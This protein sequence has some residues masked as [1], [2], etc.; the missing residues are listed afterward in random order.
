M[1][2]DEFRISSYEERSALLVAIYVARMERSDDEPYQKIWSELITR[3]SQ[4]ECQ[5]GGCSYCTGEDESY[6]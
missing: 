1:K 4:L 6:E 3:I 2:L 5:P